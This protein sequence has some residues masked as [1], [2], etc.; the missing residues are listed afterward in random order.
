MHT[1]EA[2]QKHIPLWQEHSL[3]IFALPQYAPE[4]HCRE[5]LWR[6][7]KDEW[8]EVDAY[9]RW[10]HVVNDVENVLQNDGEKYKIIFG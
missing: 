7:I 8:I 3:A 6:F 9:K 4:L 2:L 5:I 1:S 10:T